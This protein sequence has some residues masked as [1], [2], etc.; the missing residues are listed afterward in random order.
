MAKAKENLEPKKTKSAKSTSENHGGIFISSLGGK[1]NLPTRGVLGDAR[2]KVSNLTIVAADKLADHMKSFSSQFG[3][4]LSSISDIGGNFHLDE[5]KVS[6][7][8]TAEG[9]VAIMGSGISTGGTA[10]VELTFKR[11]K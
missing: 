1:S 11:I 5:V 4:A 10:G 7:E 6:L 8:I 9:Q 3:Q 2:T